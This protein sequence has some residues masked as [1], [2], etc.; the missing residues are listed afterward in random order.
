MYSFVRSL[1]LSDK[2]MEVSNTSC[3]VN[4]K[5]LSRN[6]VR[7]SDCLNEGLPIKMTREKFQR[8]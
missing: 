2:N 5:K 8:K 7:T 4:I 6:V 1:S 3:C